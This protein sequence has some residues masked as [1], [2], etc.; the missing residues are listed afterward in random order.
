MSSTAPPTDR[1][2]EPSDPAP[3]G[4]RDERWRSGVDLVVL[5]LVGIALWLVAGVGGVVATVLLA[6]AWVV[7]PNVAV[8]VL[9]LIAVGALVPAEAP[10][11]SVALPVIAVSGLLL[12]A[13]VTGDRLRDPLA[14]VLA[15]AVF[16]NVAIVVY[17]LSSLVWV[18]ALAVLLAGA[19]G[20]V[21][22]DLIALSAFGGTDE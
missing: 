12:T 6:L 10:T 17:R 21:S 3:P 8:F 2:N 4:W 22:L 5:G 19:V 11:A 7:L 13:T 9:G 18:T 16:G 20:F 15:L 14:V 1:G